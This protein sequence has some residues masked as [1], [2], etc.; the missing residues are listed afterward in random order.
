MDSPSQRIISLLP[1]ATEILFRVGAGEEVV[2][3]TH[4]CDYPKDVHS[5]PKC[6]SSLLSSDLTAKEIDTAVSNAINSDVHTIYR[7]NDNV[8]RNLRPTII[9]TQSLCAVCA[10]PQSKVDS[11]A[12]SL[13][14]HCKVVASD[15]HTLRQLFTSILDI[16]SAVGRPQQSQ[17]VVQSLKDRLDRLSAE[18]AKVA[19]LK[20]KPRVAVLEWPDPPYAP[21]HWVPD[22][23]VAAGGLVAVGKSGQKS[24]RVSWDCLHQVHADIVVCAFCGYDLYENQRQVELVMHHGHW[25]KFVR[26]KKVYATDASALFSRPGDRLV[27]GTELLAHIM[28]AIDAYRPKRG[29]ASQ[30]VGGTWIDVADL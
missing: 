10:V 3:V 16:G 29:L 23:V 26:G 6:T 11:L 19:H 30:L 21:G 20:P 8:I 7:L 12:C 9:V 18:T 2:G 22:Q 25:S 27:D 4:E 13:P 24:E 1:S 14:D 17:S 28:F 15:P 5:I